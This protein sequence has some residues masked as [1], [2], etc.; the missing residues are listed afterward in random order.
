V[1]AAVFVFFLWL[2]DSCYMYSLLIFFYCIF[3]FLLSYKDRMSLYSLCFP[4]F[5]TVE[6]LCKS[7]PRFR[8]VSVL[9]CLN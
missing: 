5:S 7:R 9:S 2:C 8:S 4:I 6:L 3:H 1:T